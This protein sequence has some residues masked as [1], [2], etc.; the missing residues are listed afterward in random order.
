MFTQD[1]RKALLRMGARPERIRT[2]VFASPSALAGA[3]VAPP[4]GGPFEVGF[5]AGGAAATWTA[6]SGTLLDVAEAAGLS[7]PA[8]CRA[9]ACGTCA[10][11]LTAG[12]IAH[13]TQPVLAPPLPTVL[14]CCAVPTSDVNVQA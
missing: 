4:L 9:G 8:G 7:L 12:S 1:V 6:G 5:T 14:L 10:Q 11:T 3:A 2:E 13:T